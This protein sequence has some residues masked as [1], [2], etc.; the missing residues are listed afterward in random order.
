M[1]AS[2]VSLAVAARSLSLNSG[3][4]T[5]RFSFLTAVAVLSL[6]LNSGSSARRF[7]SLTA[8]AARS[9][10]VNSAFLDDIY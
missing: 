2:M 6:F 10:R 3:I 8:V 4:T 7:I 1:P 5:R 9:V